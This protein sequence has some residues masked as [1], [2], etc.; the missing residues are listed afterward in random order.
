MRDKPGLAVRFDGRRERVSF[1]P[2]LGVPKV[3]RVRF[4][5]LVHRGVGE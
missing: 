4:L 3:E 2:V 5:L 1:S